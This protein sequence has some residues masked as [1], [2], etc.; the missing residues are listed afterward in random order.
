VRSFYSRELKLKIRISVR[1]RVVRQLFAAAS[2]SALTVEL[3]CRATC[4][5]SNI[6]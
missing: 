2:N 3:H 1:N 4:D 6:L 5:S